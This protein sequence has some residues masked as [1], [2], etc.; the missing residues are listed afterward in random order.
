MC[1]AKVLFPFALAATLPSPIS[2]HPDSSPTRVFG[3]DLLRACAIMGVVGA[4]ALKVFYPHCYQIG[5]LG[6]GGFFG[7]ELFFVLSGFLIG[8]ILLRLGAN[9]DN[10]RTLGVFYLR[11]WFRTL[12]L[13][14]LFIVLNVLVDRWLAH[15]SL[16]PGD[17]FSHA[18]F[19]RTFAANHVSFIPESFSL[20]IEEWFYLLFPATLFLGLILRV[21]FRVLFPALAVGFYLFSTV[22]RVLSAHHVGQSWANW[23]RVLVIYQ[24][25]GIMTGV[26]AAWVAREF[27]AAWRRHARTAGIV[28]LLLALAMYA[29]LWR[30]AGSFLEVAPD[31]FFART[32]RFNLLTLGFALLLPAMSQWTLR[33]ETFASTAVRKIALWSYSMYL[34]NLPI[35]RIFDRFFFLHWKISLVQAIAAFAT[36]VGATIAVSALLF[37]FYEAPITRLRERAARWFRPGAPA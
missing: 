36:Q 4:H 10:P 7:V 30:P 34:V 5:V 29:S 16:G 32:F 28:G 25:D 35:I 6:H 31:D 1:S 2:F 19:L 14:W 23:Q 18:F 8:G 37:R 22:G 21:E 27:P 13:F 3:L 15:R 9:L 20:A 24:F 33:T 26:V 17:I 11:R 12:P